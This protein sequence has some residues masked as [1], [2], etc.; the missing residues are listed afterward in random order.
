MKTQDLKTVLSCLD[1]TSLNDLDRFE[2]IDLLCKR[3]L[4]PLEDLSSEGVAAVCVYPR[5]IARAKKHLKGGSI[6]IATVVGG[7][8]HGLQTLKQKKL[9]TRAAIEEGAD[10]VDLVF[11]RG[12]FLSGHEKEIS[13]EIQEIKSICSSEIKLKVILETGQLEKRGAI[14]KAAEISL[15]AGADFIK[16]STGKANR[17]ASLEDARVFC[18]ALKSF[19]ETSGAKCGLKLSGGIKT[20]GEA[21]AFLELIREELG[22]EWLKKK[23]LRF[24]A[25][26]L[27]GELRTE[28][29]RGYSNEK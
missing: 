27:L 4:N 11:S 25:S 14:Q 15:K 19:R 23:F 10:E 7:F 12:L 13:E 29:K 20:S 1:L 9:E 26:S 3:A 8:P 17:G 18:A 5:F 2:D 21:L 16:T 24:G 22:E 28:I 6:K